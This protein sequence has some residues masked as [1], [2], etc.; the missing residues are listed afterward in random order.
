MQRRI[1]LL[2]KH[3]MPKKKQPHRNTREAGVTILPIPVTR[4]EMLSIKTKAR[5][6]NQNPSEWIRG[7][8]KILARAE[9]RPRTYS[10]CEHPVGKDGYRRHQFDKK[11]G[12]CWGCEKTRQQVTL[13]RKPAT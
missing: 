9:G 7:K 12:I 10:P 5:S 6:K 8:I 3:S 11:T 2:A 1:S 13:V 4:E